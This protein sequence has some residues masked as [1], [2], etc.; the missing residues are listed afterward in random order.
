MRT[1]P[2]RELLLPFL[3]KFPESQT[4][5]PFF[6]LALYRGLHRIRLKSGIAAKTAQIAFKRC[7]E[8]ERTLRRCNLPPVESWPKEGLKLKLRR[9]GERLSQDDKL[10]VAGLLLCYLKGR[11][12]EDVVLWWQEK[13]DYEIYKIITEHISNSLELF[14]S[15]PQVAE[16]ETCA[17]AELVQLEERSKRASGTFHFGRGNGPEVDWEE[18]LGELKTPSSDAAS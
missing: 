2:I 9:I 18:E 4:L 10:E 16:R 5:A 7:T 13:A 3:L 1:I 14:N 8:L 6:A 12:S 17:F 11:T 15:A